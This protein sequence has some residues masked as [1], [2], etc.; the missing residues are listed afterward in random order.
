MQ[1]I[2]GCYKQLKM[3]QLKYGKRITPNHENDG[4][5]I[6]NVQ[7]VVTLYVSYTFITN[8]NYV[9]EISIRK[10]QS[11]IY[12]YVIISKPLSNINQSLDC[13][14]T[15]NRRYLQRLCVMRE[16]GP[17]IAPSNIPTHRHVAPIVIL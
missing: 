1:P 14:R 16:S 12:E 17:H 3:A 4:M 13:L 6:R 2:F 11:S 10:R 9:F 15:Q 7:H 5:D 8:Q